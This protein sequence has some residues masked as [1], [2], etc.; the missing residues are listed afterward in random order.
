MY[1]RKFSRAKAVVKGILAAAATYAATEV[2]ALI[3]TGSL[4]LSRAEWEARGPAIA[5]SIAL[6]AIRAAQN[7]IKTRDL[8][9][10]PLYDNGGLSGY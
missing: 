7:V 2:V 3:Q 5:V 6:G 10:N 1:R 4:P 9:G 8:P